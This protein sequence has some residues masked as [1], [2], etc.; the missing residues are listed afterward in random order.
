M[1]LQYPGE[2]IHILPG[3]SDESVMKMSP[4]M[5]SGGGQFPMTEIGK[6]N[7]KSISEES[8]C[9][10]VSMKP[11]IHTQKIIHYMFEQYGK[12]T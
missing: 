11:D 7:L 3:S 6:L 8:G 12:P 2:R 1:R 4:I 10:I 5:V 9:S